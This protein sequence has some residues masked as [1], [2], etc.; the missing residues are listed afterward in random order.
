MARGKAS[1]SYLKWAVLIPILILFLL[2]GSQQFHSSNV[3][4]VLRIQNLL[5]L[6][7]LKGWNNNTKFCNL[8]TPSSLTIVCYEE[9]IT[10][11]KIVG[12]KGSLQKGNR[13]FFVSNQSLSSSFS[14]D[15]FLT[16]LYKLSSLKVLS[17]ASL[18]IQGPLLANIVHLSS[19]GILN[20]T[21]FFFSM[22]T[23][24]MS[25]LLRGISRP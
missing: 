15:S 20:T 24:Y 14:I 1:F 6:S 5:D 9:A 8:T 4:T 7:A 10:Q 23:F 12:D 17:L 16:T 22:E 3:Q 19:L 13:T 2:L 21:S 18:G 11:L 25:F